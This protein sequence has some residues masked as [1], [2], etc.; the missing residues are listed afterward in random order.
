MGV[1]VKSEHKKPPPNIMNMNYS[2]NYIKYIPKIILLLYG[3]LFLCIPN[4]P[5]AGVDCI[6]D[7]ILHIPYIS[8]R[9]IFMMLLLLYVY[10]STKKYSI[11]EKIIAA[12]NIALF[13]ILLYFLYRVENPINFIPY[14]IS[15]Y[16]LNGNAENTTII[17]FDLLLTF[18][19]GFLI[20]NVFISKF[21]QLHKQ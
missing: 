6:S 19:M 12:I 13:P 15:V 2:K 1:G 17:V 20:Q 3:I 7:G 21:N 18:G 16:L 10:K 14:S 11:S 9:V 4:M 5:E 8:G